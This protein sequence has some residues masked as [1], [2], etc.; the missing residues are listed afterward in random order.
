[1]NNRWLLLQFDEA[2]H[3]AGRLQPAVLN[4]AFP[5]IPAGRLVVPYRTELDCGLNIAGQLERRALPKMILPLDNHPD[6]EAFPPTVKRKVS[7]ALS[8]VKNEQESP[9]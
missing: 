6:F 2:E 3:I 7:E 4:I 8:S 5:E 9:A 1:M